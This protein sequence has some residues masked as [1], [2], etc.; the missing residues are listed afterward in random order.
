MTHRVGVLCGSFLA[1]PALPAFLLHGRL[2]GVSRRQRS[3]SPPYPFCVCQR[4]GENCPACV[5]HRPCRNV[6]G[7][8]LTSNTGGEQRSRCDT[9]TP[10][11]APIN[12]VFFTW[13]Q[14][15]YPLLRSPGSLPRILPPPLSSRTAARWGA[16]RSPLPFGSLRPYSNKLSPQVTPRGVTICYP[17]L[18]SLYPH[19][20]ADFARLLWPSLDNSR[21]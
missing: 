6:G 10:C 5:S 13:L 1:S 12:P 17:R 14:G 20:L 4:P 11:H 18:S 15:V 7:L 19:R 21:S 8:F 9:S 2:A 16:L 3:H